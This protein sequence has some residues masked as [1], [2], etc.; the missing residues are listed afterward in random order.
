MKSPLF[1]IAICT[2]NRQQVLQKCLNGLASQN[3]DMSDQPIIVIDNNPSLRVESIVE[4]YR[5]SLP[6]IICSHEPV[7][8]LSFA[9]NTAIAKT[10]TPYIVFIDDDAIPPKHWANT[11]LK[12]INGHA[13]DI[14]GGPIYPYYTDDRPSWFRDKYE[15]RKHAKTTG[16][17][18]NGRI[19]GGNFGVHTHL[20]KQ[21][22]CF[23][24]AYGMQGKSIRL[25]EEREFVE[26]Y[27]RHTPCTKQKIYYDLGLYVLHHVSHHKMRLSYILS[28]HYEAGKSMARIK[29][30]RKTDIPIH[31]FFFLY[32][33]LSKPLIEICK[34]GFNK[35]D[36]ISMLTALA[37][38]WG[39]IV[40]MA[41]NDN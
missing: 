12:V 15:I 6:A 39:N 8:G 16:M 31:A 33:I 14:F 34:K 37:S 2:F 22:G 41:S 19:S 24:T 23:N 10:Q 29:G 18:V 30:K 36:Y 13:P 7:S 4:S 20:F 32:Y 25:G 27:K 11:V 26:K 3:I 5:E 17:Q 28:R 9:R 38:R 35:A 1:T 40:Q 21:F